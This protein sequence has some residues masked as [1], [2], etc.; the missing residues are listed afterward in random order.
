MKN[1]TLLDTVGKT[2]KANKELFQIEKYYEDK[3]KN[4]YL[5][6]LSLLDDKNISTEDMEDIKKECMKCLTMAFKEVFVWSKSDI[7]M[8]FN[9][10][11]GSLYFKPTTVYSNAKNKRVY[12]IMQL[13]KVD[14]IFKNRNSLYNDYT[15]TNE[16]H[17]TIAY[18]MESI[19]L[20][21]A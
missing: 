17:E 15:V 14:I 9:Y 10:F 7:Y 13:V 8:S 6:D 20:E 4:N 2:L 21:I 3:Y 11:S 1:Y 19:D 18:N 12:V 5:Y 16:I